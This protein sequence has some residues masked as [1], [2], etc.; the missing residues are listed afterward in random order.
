MATPSGSRQESLR[1]EPS[2]LIRMWEA[3]TFST[4]D[5]RAGEGERGDRRRGEAAA[6]GA[7]L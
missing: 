4:A 3:R 5:A 7:T 6:P 2:C 1:R